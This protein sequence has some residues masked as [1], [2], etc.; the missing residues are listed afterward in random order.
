MVHGNLINTRR[1]FDIFKPTATGEITILTYYS[2]AFLG[3]DKKLILT[4]LT[5]Q[6]NKFCNLEAMVRAE[7]LTGLQY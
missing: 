4:C 2:K 1:N 3:L 5:S 7:V 6:S